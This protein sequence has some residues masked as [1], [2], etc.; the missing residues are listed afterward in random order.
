MRKSSKLV[1][2]VLVFAMLF[3]IN[4]FAAS[5]D[6]PSNDFENTQEY[7]FI[8]ALSLGY[9]GQKDFVSTMTRAEFL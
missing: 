4:V 1:S 2:V 6:L 5:S 8:S 3:Q 9:S 7:K